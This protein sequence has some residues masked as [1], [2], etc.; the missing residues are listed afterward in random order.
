MLINNEKQMYISVINNNLLWF[1]LVNVKT[2]L[3]EIFS[4]SCLSFL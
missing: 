1:H 2:L 3:T 4:W